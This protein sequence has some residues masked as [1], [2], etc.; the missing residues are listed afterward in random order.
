MEDVIFGAIVIAVIAGFWYT[1]KAAGM[2]VR[3]SRGD[4]ISD[5]F[6]EPPG[7]APSEAKDREH[8]VE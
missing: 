6:A 7:E 4:P 1:R 2:P 5:R 8:E 3:L